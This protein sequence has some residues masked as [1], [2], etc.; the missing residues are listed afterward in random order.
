M[1]SYGTRKFLRLISSGGVMPCGCNKSGSIDSYID[2]QDQ[3]PQSPLNVI[4]LASLNALTGVTTT[5]Q[6]M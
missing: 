6:T 1:L 5:A 4:A 3:M 2:M